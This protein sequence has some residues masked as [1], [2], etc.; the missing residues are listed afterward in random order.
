[1]NRKLVITLVVIA[2]LAGTWYWLRSRQGTT[3]PIDENDTGTQ[4]FEVDPRG[5]VTDLNYRPGARTTNT[6]QQR[7]RTGTMTEARRREQKHRR[8]ARPFD[9]KTRSG[10]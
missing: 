10:A 3:R 1:M 5:N 9:Q 4:R 8:G 6:T 2:I 7:Q